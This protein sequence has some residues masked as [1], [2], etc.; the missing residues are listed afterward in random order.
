MKRSAW[1]L[2][3]LCLVCVCAAAALLPA[4]ASAHMATGVGGWSW[5]NPLPQGNGYTG[6]Y[7]LDA[8]HGWLISRGTI[9]HTADGGVTLKVQARHDVRFSAITFVGAKHGWAV[10]TA[11]LGRR[12][13]AVSHDQWGAD[14]DARP[15]PVERRDQR[16]QLRHD[17]GRLGDP[18]A[19]HPAHD[20]RGP[21]L[22]H[23]HLEQ[24]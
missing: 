18:R 9:F 6:G 4:S 13:R 19:L 20:R 7:F 12:R 14:L 8:D 15:T 24:A 21:A 1:V 2:V 3:S 16:D 10:G 5:Q 11:H 22:D 23:T 17:R